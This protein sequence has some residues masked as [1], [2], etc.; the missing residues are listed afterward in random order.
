MSQFQIETACRNAHLSP[1]DKFLGQFF[2]FY[3]VLMC[4][5]KIEELYQVGSLFPIH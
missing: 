4:D 5:V 2:P 1:F 3:V